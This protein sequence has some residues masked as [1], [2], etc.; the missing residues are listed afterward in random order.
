MAKQTGFYIFNEGPKSVDSELVQREI[1][2]DGSDLIQ[3]KPLEE[4]VGMKKGSDPWPLRCKP[5]L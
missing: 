2:L 5:V 4:D 3:G 1:I